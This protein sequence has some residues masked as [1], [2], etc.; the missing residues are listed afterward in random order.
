MILFQSQVEEHQRLAEHY[1]ELAAQR[2]TLAAE[3]L[4]VQQ[5]A[6]INLSSLKDLV[7]KCKEASPIVIA[8]LKAAVLTLFDNGD[9]GFNDGDDG[10]NGGNQLH[11]P[12]PEPDDSEFELLCLNGETGDCQTTDDLTDADNEI[13]AITPLTYTQAIKNRCG[14]CWGY[15]VKSKADIKAGFI[16]RTNLNFM[17][18]VNLERT[19]KE[20]YQTVEAYLDRL[21]Y[22]GQTCDI[23]TAPLQGQSCDWVCPVEFFEA[24]PEQVE[25]LDEQELL[26]HPD[27]TAITYISDV[28]GKLTTFIGFSKKSIARSWLKF[29]EPMTLTAELREPLHLQSFKW[30]LRCE[31]LSM[32]QLAKLAEC[33]FTE[34]HRT[35]VCTANPPAPLYRFQ[36]PVIQI[37]SKITKLNSSEI[38]EATSLVA[39]KIFFAKSTVTGDRK[40]FSIEEVNILHEPLPEGSPQYATVLLAECPWKGEKLQIVAEGEGGY[41]LATPKGTYWYRRDCVELFDERIEKI[42]DPTELGVGD[43]VEIVSDRYPQ[44]L[45]QIGTV[46]DISSDADTPIRVRSPRGIKPYH[47]FDLK[48]ISK[49]LPF[50]PESDKELVAAGS[51]LEF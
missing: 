41:T 6:H 33:D 28:S 26:Y 18:A 32:V 43:I 23:D 29:I 31:G 20:F 1:R 38:F 21:Y 14:A 19:G 34:C 51:E 25:E 48:L 8:S 37:G 49:A 7:S 13:E 22:N 11:L 45:D 10:S 9:D 44:F 3:L 30:E 24:V 47:R 17:E 4:A 12:T 46:E 35:E 50:S 27:N 2:E 39:N 5:Q 16:N 36:P 15:E 40:L 42:A